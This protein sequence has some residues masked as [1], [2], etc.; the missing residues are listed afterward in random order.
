MY[1]FD[2]GDEVLIGVPNQA[3]NLSFQRG[4]IVKRIDFSHY[5]VEFVDLQHYICHASQLIITARP[6]LAKE[7]PYETD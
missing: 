3:N 5:L 7:Q 1:K 4:K 2:D 6:I